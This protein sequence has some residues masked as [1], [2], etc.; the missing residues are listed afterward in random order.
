MQSKATTPEEYIDSL[1]EDRK[2][3]ISDIRKVILKNLPKGFKEGIGY[4]MLC[5]SVPHS[6]YPPGYHVDP[7]QPLGLISIASQKNHIA[8][9][10]MGLYAGPLLIWFQDEW[11]K[12][13]TKKLDMGKSC[14]RF[15][16]AED[17][18]LELIG[19]LAA[20]LTPQ[21]W[22]EIYENALNSRK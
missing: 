11:K 21:K 20:K 22:I 8:M 16:K 17:V 3:I 14:V 2:K 12:S 5:Y 1:P 19:R 10:H 6:I 9:Y 13:T 4:G 7:K 18:P 15:K